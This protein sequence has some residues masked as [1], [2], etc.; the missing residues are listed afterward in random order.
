MLVETFHISLTNAYSISENAAQLSADET[1]WLNFG[2]RTTCIGD[3]T[4]CA[5]GLTLTVWIYVNNT[6]VE[7]NYYI[8]SS[9]HLSEN[10]IGITLSHKGD[11]LLV[12]ITTYEG[13]W[14][15]FTDIYLNTW[16]ACAVI[17]NNNVLTLYLNDVIVG[18][19][20]EGAT[21]NTETGLTLSGKV[22][23]GVL[24]SYEVNST[25]SVLSFVGLIDEFYFWNYAISE[26]KL[27]ETFRSTAL[28]KYINL[29]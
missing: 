24:P 12:E 19:S 15:T 10:N 29:L 26:V 5:D 9:G 7:N 1:S 28:C 20:S 18:Q 2:N 25:S 13:T 6:D 14:S 17:W 23:M 3:I 4:S 21:V 8:F 11:T 27:L 16:F 22:T